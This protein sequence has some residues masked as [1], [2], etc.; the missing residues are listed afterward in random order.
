MKT[1]AGTP[2]PRSWKQMKLTT[3]PSGGAGSRWPGGGAIHFGCDRLVLDQLLQPPLR[4]RGGGPVVGGEDLTLSC[5]WCYG[6]LGGRRGCDGGG[7]GRGRR[8]Q[9]AKGYLRQ[10]M[11]KRKGPVGEADP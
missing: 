10:R 3:Y 2:N 7:A 8:A 1:V 9:G 11:Q 4:H 5:H 6:E